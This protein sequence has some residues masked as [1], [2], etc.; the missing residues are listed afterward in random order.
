MRL[1]TH[2]RPGEGKATLW[3]AG[4]AFLLLLIYYMLKPIREALILAEH[5]A[6]MR[7]YTIA[8]QALVLLFLVPIYGNLIRGKGA[9]KTLSRV[10]L[11][12]AISLLVFG[13]LYVLELPVAVPFYVWL[14]VINVLLIAQFWAY[15][16]DVH[17]PDEGKRL[18]AFIAAGA[19]FGA[20]VGAQ[21]SSKLFQ[22]IGAQG[23]MLTAALLLLSTMWLPKWLA[24][25][26]KSQEQQEPVS[27]SLKAGF[28]TVLSSRYLLIIAAFVV[29][30][31][32]I[33]TTG[34][35]ILAKWVSHY[36][37]EQADATLYIG[38]FYGNFYTWVNLL[39]MLIQLLLVSRILQ[40]INVH[41]AILILPFVA[42]VGY[43]LATFIPI[44]SL[45]HLIKVAENSV[46]YSL[47]NTARHALFLP[48]K[49]RQ[50]YE[51]KTVIDALCWRIGDLAH[52]AIVFIGHKLMDF[53]HREFAAINLAISVLWIV[54]A[55]RLAKMNK[56]LVLEQQHEINGQLPATNARATN[57]DA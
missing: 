38:Q 5:S 53:E 6:E 50:I 44:F 21:V 43:G 54:L 31:N 57:R 56:S 52:V 10:S 11:L 30:L 51:G 35:Y 37:Q 48:L 3:L 12:V 49:Q 14:G 28:D 41:G 45:F 7:S 27:V 46:D 1:F 2:L 4:Y 32:C 22:L 23:L 33:N 8:L 15:A 39:S 13:S 17:T 26:S 55:L 20:L 19:S 29:L 40:W 18:F 24:M 34:E 16:A 25:V 42:L 9:E 47:Q 36:A